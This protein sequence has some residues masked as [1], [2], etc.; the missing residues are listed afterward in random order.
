MV[1]NGGGNTFSSRG[2]ME[3]RVGT[4]SHSRSQERPFWP[5]GCR[6]ELTAPERQEVGRGTWRSES[7]FRSMDQSGM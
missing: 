7:E 4:G 5:Q 1:L 6:L 2:E 3:G